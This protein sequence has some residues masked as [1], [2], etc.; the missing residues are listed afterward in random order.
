MK[1]YCDT[2]PDS[3]QELI[4]FVSTVLADST[5]HAES[6]SHEI[7]PQVG[8]METENSSSTV[9]LEDILAGELV[10]PESI[11]TGGDEC[12]DCPKNRY[13]HVANCYNTCR[14]NSYFA[15][16]QC[17]HAFTALITTQDLFQ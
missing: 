16:A 1:S 8:E 12:T 17:I 11:I 6:L 14:I 4:E 5:S 2:S 10:V 7:L 13:I 15:Y 9:S 3:S